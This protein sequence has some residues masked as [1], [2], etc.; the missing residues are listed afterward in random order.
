M[1]WIIT[2]VLLFA[3]EFCKE[4]EGKKKKD[5]ILFTD[6][7]NLCMLQ[8]IKNKKNYSQNNLND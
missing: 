5:E 6:G 3:C 8:M 7:L 1:V 4:K 2:V